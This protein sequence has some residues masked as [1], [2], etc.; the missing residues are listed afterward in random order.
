MWTEAHRARH[1]PRLKAVVS[2]C[3]VEALAR[4]LEDGDPPVSP[5]QFQAPPHTSTP[6]G[7]NF[8]HTFMDD[9]VADENRS[10]R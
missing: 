3:A 8:L 4:R 5:R 7:Y 1:E 9:S 10:C 2:G 6:T